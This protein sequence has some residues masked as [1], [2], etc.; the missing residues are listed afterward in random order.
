[1]TW[2]CALF[3][4]L[5]GSTGQL[6]LKL[7]SGKLFDLHTL[8]GIAFY[9]VSFLLWLKVLAAWPLSR[10]YPLLAVNFVLVAAFSALFLHEPFSLGSL[11]G[12]AL[13]T[14]GVFFIGLF[15]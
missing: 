1:M 7:G 8:V 14:L 6:Y 4:V 15:R 10:A 13:C 9:G 2:L 3:S 12:T 11:V 5:F